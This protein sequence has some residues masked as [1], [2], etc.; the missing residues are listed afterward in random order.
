MRF[1]TA[2]LFALLT[3]IILPSICLA[4]QPM[5]K[6]SWVYR[7]AVPVV[8]VFDYGTELTAKEIEQISA[9]TSLTEIRMG[10]AAIDSEYVTIEGDLLKLGRLKNLTGLHL[11]KDGINDDDLKF[12]ALLPKIQTLEF[13]ANNGYDGAPI[14]TDR[15]ADHLS[16]AKSLRVLIVHDGNFTDEFVARITKGLPDLESLQLNSPEFT[17][18]SLRLIADRCKKLKSL[19]IASDHFTEEGLKHLD[20]LTKLDHSVDSPRLRRQ[21]QHVTRSGSVIDN[22]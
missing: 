21:R 1:M 5:S 6:G 16:A 12:V 18:E 19:S 11:N 14:C 13:N 8:V 15:C 4:Q 10:F 7:D 2:V 22:D 3:N 20:R 17:D 9:I